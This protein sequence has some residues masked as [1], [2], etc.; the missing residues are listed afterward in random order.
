MRVA[1]P[2]RRCAAAPL[3]RCAAAPLRL[4]RLARLF[5]FRICR[6]RRATSHEIHLSLSNALRRWRWIAAPPTSAAHAPPP[7]SG[8]RRTVTSG[9]SCLVRLDQPEINPETFDGSFGPCQRN[10]RTGD[11]SSHGTGGGGSEE[12]F[13]CFARMPVE[14]DE[15]LFGCKRLRNGGNCRKLN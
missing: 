6:G 11:G 12:F 13:D 5:D 14:D 2:L 4:S 1:V 7:R 10:P 9:V 3:R 8:A 15:E